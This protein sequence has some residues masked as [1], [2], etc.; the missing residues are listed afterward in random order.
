MELVCV[1]W[2]RWQRCCPWPIDT[3]N[4]VFNT[5]QLTCQSNNSSFCRL[6]QLHVIKSDAHGQMI[7]KNRAP[8]KQSL[9][10]WPCPLPSDCTIPVL[11]QN[12]AT[13]CKRAVPS[14]TSPGYGLPPTAT[15]TARNLFNIELPSRHKP[16]TL[17]TGTLSSHCTESNALLIGLLG[18]VVLQFMLHL[19]LFYTSSHGL[20]IVQFSVD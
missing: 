14:L 9:V 6:L 13:Q 18:L 20:C 2:S 3:S 12:L 19:Y 10:C 8:A 5:I 17:V 7:Y 11:W 15:M 4:S 16:L 1:L